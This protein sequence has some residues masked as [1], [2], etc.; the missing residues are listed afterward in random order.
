MLNGERPD[1]FPCDYWAT[2]EVTRRLLSDL[3]CNSER[4]LWEALG[5]DKCIFLA[6]THPRAREQTWHIP[7][8]FSI[9]NIETVLVP[10]MDGLG[11]YEEAVNPPLA[12]ATTVAEIEAFAWPKPEDWD[13]STLRD[14]CV[15]WR[16]YPIVGAS[17]EPFFLYCRLRGMDQALEDV[18]VNQHIVDAVM[19]RIFDVHAGI[20]RRVL[21]TAADLIDFIY[22]AEDLG[23]QQSLL[24]SLKAFRRCIKPWL[25]RMIDLAHSYGVRAFH[26]DDGAIRPVLPD[27]IEIGVDVLNPIQWRCRG[28]EREALAAEFG[29]R[30]VFHGGIDNQYTLPFG[31]PA[32]VRQQVCENLRIFKNCKGYIVSPCHN[33]Q[34]N[35][36]TANIV[37]L[38]E[39]VHLHAV[40]T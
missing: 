13:Y 33:I 21:D 40:A 8:L 7:S 19:E 31:S 4:D 24:M 29:Q 32:D 20:V 1:R 38:Y 34:V 27:L 14:E 23:T 3:Q 39:A 26:H 17:Y 10:Y 5:V 37:A 6:P 15:R 25:A 36:P 16:D 2:D 35:T 22:V 18:L 30:L 9:W 28:M 11:V 12:D